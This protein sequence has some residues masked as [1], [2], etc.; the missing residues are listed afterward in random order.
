MKS[1]LRSA[2]RG[3][4]PATPTAS[5]LLPASLLLLLGLTGA[6]IAGLTLPFGQSLVTG[7]LA[8][9]AVVTSAGGAVWLRW[10]D[11][12]RTANLIALAGIGLMVAGAGAM[13]SA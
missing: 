12:S 6:F 7:L 13:P 11:Q 9:G 2:S 5:A 4:S 10:P 8:A 1:L 3:L